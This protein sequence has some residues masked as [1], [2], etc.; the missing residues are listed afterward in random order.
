MIPLKDKVIQ[1]AAIAL[2]FV[3]IVLFFVFFTNN[4]VNIPSV[5]DFTIAGQ[6][7][8]MFEGKDFWHTLTKNHNEHRVIT[9]RFGF[10]LLIANGNLDFTHAMFFGLPL[11][12]FLFF[13]IARFSAVKSPFKYSVASLLAFN[14]CYHTNVFM[15]MTSIQNLGILVFAG[16]AALAYQWVAFNKLKYYSGISLSLFFGLMAGISGGNGMFIF[17]ALTVLSLLNK[18][19]KSAAVY[20]ISLA[21][22]AAW[23]F[24]GYQAPANNPDAGIV[25]FFQ[26]PWPRI[27]FFLAFL[28]SPFRVVFTEFLTIAVFGVAI[29]IGIIPSLFRKDWFKENPFYTALLWFCTLTAMAAAVNRAGASGALADSPFSTR[30]AHY[31]L[32]IIAIVILFYW[33]KF[34]DK[35]SAFSAPIAILASFLIF[36]GSFYSHAKDVK[37]LRG[38]KL[39]SVVNYNLTGYGLDHNFI[40]YDEAIRDYERLSGLGLYKIPDLSNEILKSFS[41][42]PVIQVFEGQTLV[43]YKDNNSLWLTCQYL[44]NKKMNEVGNRLFFALRKPGNP[45]PVF[46]LPTYPLPNGGFKGF[47]NLQAMFD[48]SDKGA[49]AI[50]RPRFLFL[51]P[52]TY[53]VCLWTQDAKPLLQTTG[54][55]CEIRPFVPDAEATTTQ[56]PE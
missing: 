41:Q 37:Y 52:G 42:T 32:V 22:F 29:A 8:D 12:G 49:I 5:D 48:F 2:V 35:H 39:L 38:Q 55:T 51:E 40:Y 30:F 53:E 7:L 16:L 11:W 24:A 21:L 34:Q 50:V 45:K 3:P 1:M 43:D 47:R 25:A 54:K 13:C 19:I 17:V 20:F 4:A 26:N 44:D 9:A 31:G 6:A 23:Y 14:L 56:T 15:G 10:Y 36:C 28:A 33:G 27:V 46:I 18:D